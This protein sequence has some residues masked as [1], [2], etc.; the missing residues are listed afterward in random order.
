MKRSF[1]VGLIALFMLG[2][3]SKVSA[4]DR[5]ANGSSYT[6]AIGIGFD[7]GDGTLVG[8]SVKHFF[9]E[10]NAGTGELLFG[11]HLIALQAFYQYH[12]EFDGAAGLRWFVG[13]G[14]SLRFISYRGFHETDFA[15]IP[16]AGLDYKITDVPL[17]ISF[18]WRPTFY[19]THSIGTEGGRFGLGFRYALR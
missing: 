13:A 19:L 9:S 11:N 2:G 15:L 3:V 14:P 10:N 4:Q 18:D 17:T 8:P 1:L 6:N 7:F 12:K 16:M 5:A